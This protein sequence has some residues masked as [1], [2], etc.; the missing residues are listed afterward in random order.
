MGRGK[1]GAGDPG[2]PASAATAEKNELG[3]IIF[4][5]NIGYQTDEGLLHALFSPYGNVAKVCTVCAYHV[6]GHYIDIGH[7]LVSC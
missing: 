5:Y 6:A 2:V 1:P 4:A 7:C 3:Y